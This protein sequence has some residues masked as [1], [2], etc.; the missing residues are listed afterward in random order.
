MGRSEFR[1]EDV[2]ALLVACHRRCC[3]CHKFGGVKLEIDHIVPAADGTSGSI[4][5]AI[6]LCFDCHAEVHYYNPSHPKGRSFSAEELRRHKEQWL[7][8]C[9]ERPDIFVHAQ[10]APEAGSLERLLSEM[11]FNFHIASRSDA[12][13]DAG[14]PFELAQFRRAIAD[15]TFAWLEPDL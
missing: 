11:D 13:K 6:P 14:T 3:V 8:I 9:R 5:N 4:D 2:E 1:A 15:G 10:P 12:R 7:A